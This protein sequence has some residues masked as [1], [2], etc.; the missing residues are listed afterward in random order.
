MPSANCQVSTARRGASC[1]GGG[2][3]VASLAMVMALAGC[4]GG[5]NSVGTVIPLSPGAANPPVSATTAPDSASAAAA[6]ASGPDAAVATPGH[7]AGPTEPPGQ[8]APAASRPDPAAVPGRG[9]ITTT[10]PAALAA[11]APPAPARPGWPIAIVEPVPVEATTQ[12][13]PGPVARQPGPTIVPE[14]PAGAAREEWLKAR[15]AELEADLDREHRRVEQ[16]QGRVDR[17]AQALRAEQLAR[18]R[19]RDMHDPTLRLREDLRQKLSRAEALN[20][21]RETLRGD[22]I[23]LKA[24]IQASDAELARL[25]AELARLGGPR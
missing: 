22:A 25:R 18:Q 9:P 12:P 24:M 5:A 23:R 21:E 7:V 8:P 10:R 19:D 3:L 11:P 6:A 14:P 15:V 16:A 2:A 13:G 17:A 1:A 20:L 4:P